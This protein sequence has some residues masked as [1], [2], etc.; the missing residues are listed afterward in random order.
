MKI[1]VVFGILIGL[2]QSKCRI[3]QDC[4]VMDPKCKPSAAN[5][6]EPKVIAAIDTICPEYKGQLACCSKGQNILLQK[7]LDALDSVFG[8]KYGGCDVC[9]INLKKFWC[10]FTCSPD[11]DQWR[12]IIYSMKLF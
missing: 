8:S 12:K 3:Q 4:N 10:H 1:F 5:F 6:T 2:I 7:N 9:A 11:Q